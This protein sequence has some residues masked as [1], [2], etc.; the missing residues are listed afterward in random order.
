[1]LFQADCLTQSIKF[2]LIYYAAI[3][4]QYNYYLNDPQTYTEKNCQMP[5][6]MYTPLPCTY[7]PS[8]PII[9][10]NSS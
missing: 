9:S 10:L 2:V 8:L 3:E 4:S 7:L 5:H 6:K 1:M